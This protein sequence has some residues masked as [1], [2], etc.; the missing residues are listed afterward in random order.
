MR[1]RAKYQDKMVAEMGRNENTERHGVKPV[2][3]AKA[4]HAE[5]GIRPAPQSASSVIAK[6][7]TQCGMTKTDP[8]REMP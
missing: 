2:Q 7:A 1:R 6:N 8:N 4:R 5:N 3:A